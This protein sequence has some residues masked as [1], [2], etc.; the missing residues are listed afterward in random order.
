MGGWGRSVPS[1]P[2]QK[3]VNKGEGRQK[4]RRRLAHLLPR[5]NQVL[6]GFE[7]VCQSLLDVLLL[8]AGQNS[9]GQEQRQTPLLPVGGGGGAKLL[10]LNLVLKASCTVY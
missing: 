2:P 1:R 3:F 5:G 4:R 7:D 10:R 8:H 9:G 6:V